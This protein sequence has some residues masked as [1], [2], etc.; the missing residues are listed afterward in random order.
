M[1]EKKPS[2]KDNFFN[3]VLNYFIE[4]NKES[5]TEKST[6]TNITQDDDIAF[7][8]YYSNSPIKPNK[9]LFDI[10]PKEIPSIA[11]LPQEQE[12]KSISL[13]KLEKIIGGIKN[14]LN[15][16][17]ES[18]IPNITKTINIF[19]NIS[20]RSLQSMIKNDFISKRFNTT[21]QNTFNN[22]EGSSFNNQEESSSTT[23]II[24]NMLHTKKE[25]ISNIVNKIKPNINIGNIPSF[26]KGTGNNPISKPTIAMVGD[27]NAHNFQPNPEHII[28]ESDADKFAS[29]RF[30]LDLNVLSNI[31]KSHETSPM[32]ENQKATRE[33]RKNK[34]LEQSA[35]Q[36]NAMNSKEDNKQ[37]GGQNPFTPVPTGADSSNKGGGFNWTGNRLQTNNNAYKQYPRWRRIL[38]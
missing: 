6:A 3:A 11:S 25:Q 29:N 27:A 26:A 33:L 12:N 37:I 32:N 9:I 35:D 18:K 23:S 22:Q 21:Q 36:I 28:R 19:E 8:K 24:K 5:E 14:T 31:S 34:I 17:V 16:F 1:S 30:N 10:N 2:S 13:T 15:G 38:G 7:T 4:K 20:N